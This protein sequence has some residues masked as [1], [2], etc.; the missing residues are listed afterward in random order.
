MQ[1]FGRCFGVVCAVRR[2][3]GGGRGRAQ[4]SA[5]LA[6]YRHPYEL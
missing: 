1:A 5:G 3:P 6:S 4:G 2:R